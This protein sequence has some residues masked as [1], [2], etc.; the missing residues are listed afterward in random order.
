MNPYYK[1]FLFIYII[2]TSFVFSRTNNYYGRISD[3]NSGEPLIGVNIYSED[4]K[5]GTVSDGDGYFYLSVSPQYSDS[6][7][8]IFQYIGYETKSI[9]LN[10]LETMHEITMTP[11]SLYSQD[12]ILVSSTR[13]ENESTLSHQYIQPIMIKKFA[14]IGDPDLFRYIASQGGI[15]FTNDI[16]NKIYIR[17]M[18]SDKLF[19]LF[20]DFVLYNPYHLVS[21]TSSIDVGAIN[22]IE[23]FKSVYPVNENGRTG[24]MLK[25][26]TKKGNTKRFR[27]YLNI[28]L[29]SS[30]LR[31]EGP[32]AGGSFMVSLRR[33]YIDFISKLFAD[34]FPYSF[35]DGIFKINFKPK[36]NKIEISGIK[37]YDIFESSHNEDSK[38]SNTAL[39]VNWKYY[40]SPQ[41]YFHNNLGYSDYASSFYSDSLN[42]HNSVTD[43]SFK[44]NVYYQSNFL[45]S[46]INGGFAAHLFNVK[47]S[48]DE[49][50]L[51]ILDTSVRTNQFD[52]FVNLSG[53]ISSKMKFDLGLS[54]VYFSSLKT[55]ELLP[56]IRMR[57]L[58]SNSFKVAAGYAKKVQYLNTVNNERD[59]LPPFNIWRVA[60]NTTGAEIS[61]QFSLSGQFSMDNYQLKSELYYNYLPNIIDFNRKYIDND[62]P[63]F[64]SNNGE[65]YGIELSFNYLNTYFS[66][67]INYTLSRT[68]YS[69]F[70]KTYYPSFHRLHKFDINLNSSSYHGWALSLHWTFSSGRPYTISEGYYYLHHFMIASQPQSSHH[71]YSGYNTAAYPAYQRLDVHVDKK[72]SKKFR[73]FFDIINVYNHKNVFYYEIDKY[74]GKKTTVYMLPILPNI[75]FEY[76][77]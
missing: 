50:Y 15:S 13:I 19:I 63:L 2:L 51:K 52:A 27:A 37:N 24:G 45:N 33:T 46:I 42:T 16:S 40:F 61:R 39:G 3:K 38:W 69:I 67:N 47:F 4:G 64:L 8:I 6:T 77:F 20:D 53:N 74:S 76:K 71:Y 75:G 58:F 30:I 1:K 48:S 54:A 59:Y 28:S 25:I 73:L 29:M 21:I 5:Y 56:L 41:L 72:I 34:E 65:S 23:L 55:I 7:F 66:A 68:I 60:D 12:S 44:S 31:L 35:Y 36:N 22:T 9:A 62:D 26:Y 17:G 18:R 43:F 14:A 32:A 70:D 49:D 10:A 11:R 57:Y